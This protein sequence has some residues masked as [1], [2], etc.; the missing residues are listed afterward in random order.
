MPATPNGPN[1]P[2]LATTIH[3]PTAQGLPHHETSVF[4]DGFL[5]VVRDQIVATVFIPV[6]IP[7]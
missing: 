5:K 7:V 6:I 3:A 4:L 1:V 2:T